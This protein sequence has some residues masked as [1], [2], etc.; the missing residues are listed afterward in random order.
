[1]NGGLNMNLDRLQQNFL[2]RYPSRVT[3]L[4]SHTG[5]EPTRLIVGGPGPVEGR[6]MAEKL[7]YFREHYDDLRLLLTREPRGRRGMLAA[8][9]TEPVSPGAAFGLIYMDARRYPYLCGHATIGAVTTLVELGAIPVEDGLVDLGVDTPSGLMQA[10]AVMN[11]NRVESVSFRAVPSFVLETGLTVEVPGWG[12]VPVDTVCVGGF[13]AM[14]D[15]EKMGLE[16]SLDQAPRLIELGMA[17]IAAANEQITVSHPLRPEVR[18]VDVT[19][20]YRKGA[21]S[22]EGT[23]RVIYGESHLDR[24]PCGTGTTAKLTLL[25]QSGLIKVG[26]PYINSGP[27]GTT[28][29]ARVVEET[30]VGHLPAVVVEI[31][32]SAVVTGRLEFVLDPADP[33][34]QGFL[35]P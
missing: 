33:F 7:V 22:G 25:H 8:C 18:T 28:F 34:P 3:A 26:Q 16:L 31:Q 19:E 15:A 9:L 13:F 32:G 14:V 2:D 21:S 29:Q 27:L 4:D 5:G 10:R 12:P 35:L 11:G 6:T 23:G 30:L 1:M 20:F 17:V 24:S